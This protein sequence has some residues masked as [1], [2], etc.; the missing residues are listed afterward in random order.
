MSRPLNPRQLRFIERYLATGNATQSYIDA[1]YKSIGHAAE[2]SAASLLRNPEVKKTIDAVRDKAAA[3]HGIT[4]EWYAERVK[5]EAERDGEGSSHGAR[6]SALRLAAELLGVG[7]PA[8]PAPEGLSFESLVRI[9]A[10]LGPAPSVDGS[11]GIAP[12]GTDDPLI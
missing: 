1:G 9:V 2:A 8:P 11:E 3:K 12:A 5:L 6:V 10:A 7:A 4:A